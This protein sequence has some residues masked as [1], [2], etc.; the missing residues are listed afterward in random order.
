MT[1]FERELQKLIVGAVHE[2]MSP[3]R[4]ALTTLV[5]GTKL[6]LDQV[7]SLTDSITRLEG[8]VSTLVTRVGAEQASLQSV[9]DDLKAHPAS[10]TP[11]L[12]ALITRLDTVS[13]NLDAI[14]APAPAPTPVEQPA[15]VVADPAP[16]ANP[17][18]A[19]DNTT[20]AQQPAP[21]TD[22]APADP[23]APANPA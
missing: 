15:A 21:V 10:Q 22:P 18:L 20:P 7:Q 5:E 9:I 2:A 6:M 19:V 16:V 13:A 11:D 14:D 4:F 1:N 8:K 17:T 3:Y 23:A 12:S